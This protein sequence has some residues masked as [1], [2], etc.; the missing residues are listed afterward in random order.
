MT[1]SAL[2][3][4]LVLDLSA[5]VSGAF[6][7]K[8][9]ADLG[10]QVVMIEPPEGTALRQ[11]VLFDYLAGGKESVVPADDGDFGAWLGAAD[12]VLTDGSSPWHASAADRRPD[13]AV[14]VDLSPFGR[15]GPYAEWASSDLVTWAMGGYLYFTGSPDREPIWVPGPHAQFHAGAHGALAALVGLYERDRSGRGQ[16][17]EVAD[18]DAAITAHAW[19]V[20]SWAACGVLLQR[21]PGDLIRAA[22]GWAYVM[23]IVPKD[24]LFVMIDRPDFAD[25]NLTVDLQTWSANIPRIFE[26]VAAW[27]KDK[28]VAEIVELGQLL[29]VAVTPVL[30]GNG[31]L[32]DEQLEARD[33]WSAKATWPIPASPTSCRPRR[34]NAAVRHRRSASTRAVA[35]Q[36]R[37]PRRPCRRQRPTGRHPSTGCASSRSPPTG[38]A[39]SPAASW[40]TSAPTVSRSSGPRARPHVRCSGRVP[41]RT[42]SASPTTVPSTSTR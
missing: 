29:R 20:S 22:D 41:S 1:A 7:G 25:E 13:A 30:D 17:V 23:R 24:E 14:L 16:R 26:A 3:G 28:T 6:A 42:S 40:P 10:A 19:L 37:P 4:L 32:A 34:R 27:A 39:R 35:P 31:V 9:L 5:A 8:L 11:H 18:L 15:S 2:D 33:W 38:R 21:Q 36:R 12:V